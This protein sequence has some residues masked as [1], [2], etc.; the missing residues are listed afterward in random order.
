MFNRHNERAELRFHADSGKS[1]LMLAPRRIGKTWL[2]DRLGEDLRK[3]S[4]IVIR[5]D[6]QDLS[7]ETDFLRHL[8]LRIEEQGDLLDRTK[9]RVRQLI[10]Q[11]LAN[12]PGQGLKKTLGTT[13]WKS[14]A[15]T[16]IRELNADDRPTMILIDE[17]ALF[18]AAILKRSAPAAKEFLYGLRSLQQTY[19]KVRWLFTG[20]IGLDTVARRGDIAGALVNLHIFPLEPLSRDA[21]HAFVGHLSATRQVRRPFSLDAATFN[22]FA[23][24]LGW[25]APFYVEKLAHMIVPT[26]PNGANRLPTAT[27]ADV[28]AAF[29]AILGRAYRTYFAT[30]EEH[31][32]KNFKPAEAAA[33]RRILDVCCRHPKGAQVE[34]LL[35]Q[36]PNPLSTANRRALREQLNTLVN[37]GYLTEIPEGSSLP[38][39]FRS[40][41][42]R[43]YWQRYVAE[44]A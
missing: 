36:T 22:V 30:W 40:G 26:G 41:L 25:L 15:D 27:I 20:S 7:K 4:W 34:T 29:D 10:A 5:C 44:L 17:L 23:D 18:V 11:F 28:E 16:L 24:M 8:C 13:D 9:G 38:Y 35:A 1:I 12:D 31:L 37:D 32:S 6:V 42:L 2:I 21:A 39:V 19:P 3:E 43:R 14:F 33:M